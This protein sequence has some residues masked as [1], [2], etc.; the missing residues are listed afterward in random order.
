MKL[1]FRGFAKRFVH[2]K[3]ERS[4]REFCDALG[5]KRVEWMVTNQHPLSRFVTP[6]LQKVI[7]VAPQYG[8]VGD[9]ISDE[10]FVQMLPPW[11]HQIVEQHGEEGQAW[12]RS[13]IGWLRSLFNPTAPA[14]GVEHVKPEG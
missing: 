5:E 14:E 1:S 7:S 8:W 3:A 11:V 6:E 13:T 2:I 12:L 9:A 10:E 4:I